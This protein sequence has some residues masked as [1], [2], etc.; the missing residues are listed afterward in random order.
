M[1]NTIRYL[2]PI[3]AILSG[4]SFINILKKGFNIHNIMDWI[5]SVPLFLI[6]LILIA[7]IYRIYINIIYDK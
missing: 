3:I 2:G 4:F 1:L 6:T 7:D 5:K